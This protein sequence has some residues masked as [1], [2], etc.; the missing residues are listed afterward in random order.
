MN[1]RITAMIA[2]VLAFVMALVD[3][4]RVLADTTPVY[5]SDVK[6]GMGKKA[7]EAEAAL[8]GYTIVTNNSGKYVD[9]N[10]NAGGWGSKGEMV[11]Y[12]GYQTT[13]DRDEA[14]SDI[15]LMNMKGAY[16]AKPKYKKE[17]GCRTVERSAV[18]RLFLCNPFVTGTGYNADKIG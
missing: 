17:K 12:I 11:V 8:K 4:V 16:N 5:I 7:S 9:F 14:V 2:L 13:T 10:D 3:P 15:A 1:K 18:R 6:V